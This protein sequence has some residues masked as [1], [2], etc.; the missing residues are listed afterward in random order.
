MK[1]WQDLAVWQNFLPDGPDGSVRF[2]AGHDQN[3]GR[4]EA[5]AVAQAIY[6]I[7]WPD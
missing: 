6:D 7:L 1:D 2:I 3:L 5:L 4:G